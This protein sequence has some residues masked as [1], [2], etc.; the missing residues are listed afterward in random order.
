MAKKTTKKATDKVEA[1]GTRWKRLRDWPNY[2]VSE[3]GQIRSRTTKKVRKVLR[4][5]G[6]RA[7]WVSLQRMDDGVPYRKTIR[8]DTAVASAWVGKPTKRKSTLVHI[9]GDKGNC[10]A[11]NLEYR[12]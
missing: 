7:P 11:S 9:D 3:D 6:N 4:H 1:N 10:A 2:E 12:A 5:L 8:L